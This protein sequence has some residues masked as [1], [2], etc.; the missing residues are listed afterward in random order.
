MDCGDGMQVAKGVPALGLVDVVAKGD[1]DGEKVPRRPR[2]H[3]TPRAPS[4]SKKNAEAG[5]KA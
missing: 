1:D 3:R 4:N 5:E 2:S